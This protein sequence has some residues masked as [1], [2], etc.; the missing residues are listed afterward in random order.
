MVGFIDDKTRKIFSWTDMLLSCNFPFSFRESE[1]ASNYVK[2]GSLST[3]SPVKYMRLLVCEVETVI[4]SIL[5]K[6]FEIIFDGWTFRPEHYVA[7]FASFRHDGKTHNIL[8]AMAP[9]IDDE[10][11]DHTT[12]SHFLDTILSYYGHS[13]SSI[14]YIVDDNCPVNCAVADQLKVPTVGCASHR[15]NLAVNLLLADDDD[16]LEKIQKLMCKL[17]NSLLE[18][19]KLRRKTLLRP[20]LRQDTRWSSTYAMVAR[21]FELKEYLD[22]DDD[23][24]ELVV[25][26]PTR[27][28][29][30]QLYSIL[31][32]LK[33]ADEITVLD[34]RDLFDALIAQNPEVAR[35]LDAEAAIVKCVD[36]ERA[37]I[38]VLLGSEEL[39]SVR[40]IAMLEPLVAGAAP[41]LGSSVPPPVDQGFA[42]LALERASRLRQTTPRFVDHVAMTAPTSNIVER[43]FSQAMAV[44]GMHRQAMPPMYLESILFLKVNRKYWN[45]ATV[46]KVVRREQ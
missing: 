16:L 11:D 33:I 43:F 39:M 21:Y 35:Y 32:N 1:A 4:A 34:V 46:R 29:E 20:V 22:N 13:K 8:I 41:P 40:E 15:L 28:E 42:A 31:N 6:S 2:I 19:A 25:S 45:A 38:N 27:R 37:C 3:D 18:A 44:V 23:D 26:I 36:F 12:S 5:P 10:V 14:A 9:I 24:D 7:V 17:K 30:K